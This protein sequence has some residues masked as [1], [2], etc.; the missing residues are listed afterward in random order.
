MSACLKSKKPKPHEIVAL[1][2]VSGP[3]HVQFFYLFF[4]L[5]IFFYK[6]EFL[7]QSNLLMCVKLSHRDLNPGSYPPYPTSIYT[8]KVTITPKMCDDKSLI[9]LNSLCIA[10][11]LGI[12]I[13]ES[14]IF[15]LFFIT[16]I[17]ILLKTYVKISAKFNSQNAYQGG[18]GGG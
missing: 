5:F 13:N 15:F 11:T 16:I 10:T 6:I 14:S 9:V 17:N 4:Y 18:G 2:N 12:G 1:P 3:S 8:C 7:L